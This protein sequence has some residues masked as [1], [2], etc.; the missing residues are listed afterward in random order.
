MTAAVENWAE[1]VRAGDVRALSRAI[2]AIENHH[3]EAEPL[4]RMLFPHTGQAYL[5]GVDRR[6]RHGEE[7]LVDRL[8][9]YYRKQQEAGR[10]DRGGSHQSVFR[11]SDSGRSH[12]HAGSRG[13]CGHVHSF[14]G[15]AG[16][17]GRLVARDVGSG[18]AAGRGRERQSA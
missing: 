5:I 18:A 3:A 8:A 9:A 4:L 15:H 2:T 13:R 16:I 7:H 17:S 14:D 10:R 1:Q 11:R 12:S 6:A